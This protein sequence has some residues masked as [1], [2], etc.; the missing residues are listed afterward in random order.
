MTE[1]LTLIANTLNLPMQAFKDPCRIRE[2]T[3]M[4]FIGAM[5]LTD[6][7]LG[8]S[9]IGRIMNKDH[10]SVF[11]MIKAGKDLIKTGN[12]SFTY[13]WDKVQDILPD[14]I[15]TRQPPRRDNAPT[16]EQ[17]PEMG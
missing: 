1:I 10:K 14:K 17:L 8:I 4:R 9:E 7:G 6:M 2:Y 13:K 16:M 12:A 11:H 5:V 3:E 15:K